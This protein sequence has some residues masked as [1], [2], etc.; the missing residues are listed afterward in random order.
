MFPCSL[1]A[2]RAILAGLKERSKKGGKTPIYL[3]TSG[4]SVVAQGNTGEYDSRADHAI[5]DNSIEDIKNIPDSALHREGELWLPRASSEPSTEVHL[6]HAVDL[7]IIK[8]NDEG[9]VNGYIIAPSCIYAKG[10]GPV[11]TRSAQIPTLIRLAVH[12]GKAAV[13]G[14]GGAIWNEVHVEDLGDLYRRVS[15]L[16]LS[17][18]DTSKSGFARFYF[19]SGEERPWGQVVN[20]LAE[21]LHVRLDRS[22]LIFSCA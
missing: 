5:N 19:G 7:A 16:A 18:D 4:T 20:K 17:G 15:K 9:W 2:V 6:S 21:L 14:S 22:R 1:E 3:H 13:P 10:S 11:R 8:A 12:R